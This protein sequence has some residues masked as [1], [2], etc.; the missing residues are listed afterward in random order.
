MVATRMA[1]LRVVS[2][3]VLSSHLA[4]PSHFSTVDPEHLDASNRLPK[5]LDKLQQEIDATVADNT[6][7]KEAGQQ[8]ST[9][10][11]L[12]EV[13]YDWC[14]ALH[15]FFANRGYHVVSGLY[16]R[17]FNGY[18]GVVTAYPTG[19]LETVTVDISR[20]A[21]T[22]ERDWPEEAAPPSS[23]ILSKLWCRASTTLWGLVSSSQNQNQPLHG[24]GKQCQVCQ[25]LHHHRQST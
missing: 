10:F 20:L 8:R 19:T 11:C 23:N 25:G 4:S 9:I 24:L 5:L 17:S 12:Q 21:D 2:Y 3:N 14:G 22:Y 15:V 13:S 1:L 6:K 18:M 16:G 7:N